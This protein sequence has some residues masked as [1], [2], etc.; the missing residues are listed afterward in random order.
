MENCLK[1]LVL[2]A[3]AT[4]FW[5]P[6]KGGWGPVGPSGRKPCARRARLEANG[7][8][9]ATAGRSKNQFRSKESSSENSHPLIRGNVLCHLNS[10][11]E[12][13]GFFS[14]QIRRFAVKAQWM[15]FLYSFFAVLVAGSLAMGQSTTATILGTIRDQ[16]GAVLPGV[17][18]QVINQETGRIRNTVTD[19]RGRYRVPALELGS[20][21]VQSSISGFRTLSRSGIVLTVGS[22]AVVDLAM[23]VGQV[24]ES[25][26]VTGEAP[27]VETT[28][29]QVSGLVG[30]RQ[31]RDLPLNGRSYDQLAFLQPGVVRYTSFSPAT[32]TRVFNGAGTKMSVSGT[33]TDFNSFLLD[34]T[35]LHDT[36]NFTPGSVGGNNLGVDSIQEFRVLTQNYSAEYGRSGGG[37]ISAATRAGTNSLRGGV[38]EFLRNNAVDARQFFDQGDAPPFRRNQ[39]GA[40][41][42]GPIIRD[43]TFFFAN[44]EGLRERLALTR[45]STVPT[46][47]ARRG[48][49]PNQTVTVNPV[50][51]PYLD[52][53]QQPNGKN[54]GDGTA[55]FLWTYSQPTREDFGSLRID[56]QF[57]DRFFLFGRLTVQDAEMI[58]PRS[59]PMFYEAGRSRN[60]FTT[61]EQKAIISAQTL[62]VARFA[63]NRTQGADDGGLTTISNYDALTFVPGHRWN[64]RFT[65][66]TGAG[67]G[68]LTEIGSQ[69]SQPTRFPQNIYQISDD[70]YLNRGLHAMKLG[71]NLERIQNNM[72]ENTQD[73]SHSFSDLPRFLL[74]RPNQFTVNSLDSVNGFGYR[75]WLLGVYFQDDLRLRPS[76][77][78]NFGLRYEIIT[79]PT[80]VHGWVSNIRNVRT[81]TAPTIGEAPYNNPSLGNWAPRVGFAWSPFADKRTAVRGG[82]GIYHNQWMGKLAVTA[83][84]SAFKKQV[85]LQNPL[86]PMP[87]LDNLP[88]GS[89]SYLTVDPDVLT[90]TVYQYN[91]TVERQF[92][93]DF[94]FTAGYVGHH[95]LHWLRAIEANPNVAQ[96]LPNG[97]PFFPT[98]S[99][100]VNRN[101]GGVEQ[102]GTDAI[103][104]YHALQLRLAKNYAHRVQLAANYTFSKGINDG[105]MWRSAQTLSTATGTHIP[106]QRSSDRSL[107]PYHQ[108]SVFTFNTNVR[109]PGDSLTGWTGA[110]G[111]GW[112]ANSILTAT[113]GLPF[114]V[115]IPFNNSSNGDRQAPD[116]PN[117]VAGRSNNPIVGKVERWFDPTAFSLPT[118]GTYGNLGRDTVIAPG[119]IGLDFSLV[120]NFQFT[121]RNTLA[122]RAEFF[123]ILNHA[124]FGLPNRFAFTSSGAIAGNAG[125]IQSLNT[126]ARQ[127]QFGL[128]YSF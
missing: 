75:Q 128:R 80:E 16:T 108:S 46:P 50:V 82:V 96:Y 94:V 70:V 87:S 28:N 91:L 8:I 88:A 10:K 3:E 6:E 97:T 72:Y 12:T 9:L 103:S 61:L 73:G 34:G 24:A 11:R 58:V 19:A 54:F 37:I 29:A 93:T 26:T 125:R 31:I 53:L 2:E 48:I 25:V 42:G 63:F 62:N 124:N 111:K 117:L 57:S 13:T 90:P 100:R 43:R 101:F 126:S 110:L 51:Q 22:E 118:R 20:Y 67:G 17:S 95:G 81:D 86:F 64:I 27:L 115:A 15:R 23:E 30:E 59:F 71:V 98:P 33:P 99:V 69:A 7:C 116:R 74:G 76:L 79:V 107:S 4:N 52:L 60:V 35:D 89:I 83:P 40:F 39:F 68:A 44:Y 105:S 14:Q 92:L 85:N 21:T 47:D 41:A 1:K 127:I 45:I 120:K 32:S 65:Q 66:G 119:I 5:D 55:E 123:N 122:F 56:H 121:E 84:E 102:I 18:V 113:T 109:F 38:F 106:D 36:A 104:N 114:S 49:L 78:L 77:T 112:E